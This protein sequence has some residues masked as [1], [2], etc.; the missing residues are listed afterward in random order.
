MNKEQTITGVIRGTGACVPERVLDNNEIAGF[1]DTS[2]KWIRERTGVERRRIVEK[3]TTVSMAAEAGRQALEEAGV[4]PEEVD[5]ILVATG[6]ADRVFPCT[7]CQVQEI[8]GA[9]R[10]VGFDLNAACS[11]FLF[12]YNTAQAYISS[13]ICRTILVI[14]SES[15][16]RL[17]DWTD[18]GTC[19]LF[20]D[21]AGAVL[22]KAAEGK[23]YRP[24]AHSDGKGGSALTGP[25]A[26]GRIRSIDRDCKEAK[27]EYITMN[28]KDVFQFAVR[29]VPQVIQ[30]VLK[31]NELSIEDIDWFVLHQANARIVDAVARRLRLDI[32]KFPMNLQDY[33]NTSS[34]SIPILLNEL[35][36][37]GVL[38]KGQKIILA[39]FGA[40][41]SWGASVLE[42]EI[43]SRTK[44]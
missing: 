8:L 27:T 7:A 15:L 41:L 35:N 10:A 3:E 40:G 22:L 39:G 1:V 30:E 32:G 5:M 12:A 11:G 23:S 44:W 25:G 24:A 28:G 42:W 13:G 36:R 4:S 14:G 20:G 38:K 43:D 34:A 26:A 17:V 19:I 6:S 2:D 18:R 31:E 9:V 21:G 16:S 33:G 37:K 29:N